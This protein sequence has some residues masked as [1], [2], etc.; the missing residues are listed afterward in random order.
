MQWTSRNNWEFLA[1]WLIL[2]VIFAIIL[3]VVIEKFVKLTRIVLLLAVAILPFAS[4]GIHIVRQ[5]Y[6]ATMLYSSRYLTCAIVILLICFLVIIS[7]YVLRGPSLDTIMAGCITILILL[8]PISL[9]TLYKIATISFRDFTTV[10]TR[11]THQFKTKASDTGNNI[12]LIM[13]DE[14]SYD[15]L[16]E[17]NSISDLYP[18]IKTF[19]AAADN[20]H[21]VT[22]PGRET[23]LSVPALLLGKERLDVEIKGDGIFF[24]NERKELIALNTLSNSLLSIAKAKGYRTAIYGYYFDYLKTFGE[25]LDYCKSFSYYN[26]ATSSN[27]FS[28]L[29][30]VVTTLIIWPHQYPFGLLKNPAIS[31]HVKRLVEGIYKLGVSVFSLTDPCF[32]FLQFPIPHVPYIYDASGYHPANDPFLDNRINYVN[33]LKYVDY[34]FGQYLK[35]MKASGRFN[36]STVILLSDHNFRKM[37]KFAEWSRI[38]LII[39]RPGQAERRDV[40][41]PVSGE[42]IIKNLLINSHT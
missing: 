12:Y 1:A 38:P 15:F 37:S 41:E 14:M 25:D 13:F 40:H 27:R 7:R 36:D 5:L 21:A 39:K 16:Y 30:P 24:L 29:N 42:A 6:L 28:I 31:S 3:W 33:Q 20:Y 35:E 23:T 17:G 18:N 11:P 2:S 9:L 19:A 10:P 8:S 32:L 34:L 26:Y 4:L 22:A